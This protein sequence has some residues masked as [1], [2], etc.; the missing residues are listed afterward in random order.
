MQNSPSPAARS[1]PCGILMGPKRRV[2]LLR[3]TPAIALSRGRGFGLV[4]HA[5]L[6]RGDGGGQRR[7]RALPRRVADARARDVRRGEFGPPKQR[8]VGRGTGRLPPRS[9]K[10]SGWRW[11]Q[12]PPAAKP[13]P[14]AR[15]GD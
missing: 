15:I 12:T 10:P 2:T 3:V 1:A 4:A 6:P 8:R 11:G 14:P 13:S 5:G 7:L 9:T